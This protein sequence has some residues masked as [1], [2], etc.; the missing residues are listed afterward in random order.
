[1]P[2]TY[3]RLPDCDDVFEQV[4]VATNGSVFLVNRTRTLRR[5]IE[6]LEQTLYER[7]GEL[8]ALLQH[9]ASPGVK[10]EIIL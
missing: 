3:I 1:M 8:A 4:G 7:R 5:E 10:V 6:T 2:K 9:V